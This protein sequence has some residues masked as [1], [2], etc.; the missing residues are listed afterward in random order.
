MPN[1]FFCFSTVDRIRTA[2]IKRATAMMSNK[3]TRTSTSIWSPRRATEETQRRAPQDQWLHTIGHVASSLHNCRWC[4]PNQRAFVFQAQET[5]TLAHIHSDA[6]TTRL[7]N[8]GT[9][10]FLKH[11]E[12]RFFYRYVVFPSH[13]KDRLILFIHA[14]GMTETTFSRCLVFPKRFQT[15]YKLWPI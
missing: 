9:D 12:H 7:N 4:C 11:L 6:G 8:T 5:G 1:D 14:E 2:Y 10:R 15:L 13:T 3:N